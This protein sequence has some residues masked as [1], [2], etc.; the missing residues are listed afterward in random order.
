MDWRKLF[1]ML[2]LSLYHSTKHFDCYFFP[3]KIVDPED[4]LEV[5]VVVIVTH[6]YDVRRLRT[7][8]A[9]VD[10]RQA[11]TDHLIS[12]QT[13]TLIRTPLKSPE[14]VS[15]CIR[16]SSSSCQMASIRDLSRGSHTYNSKSRENCERKIPSDHTP[17]AMVL[18]APR[19]AWEPNRWPQETP[20]FAC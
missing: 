9:I 13:C 20:R 11:M 12:W 17:S 14:D 4:S 7:R 10:C 15:S 8:L 5:L 18:T 19:T 3:L 16:L 6:S 1:Q 2:F